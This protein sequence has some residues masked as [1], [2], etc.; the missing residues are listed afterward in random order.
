MIRQ[1]DILEYGPYKNYRWVDIFGNDLDEGFGC[2][3]IIYGRNYAGKTTFSRIIRSLELGKPHKDFNNGKFIITLDDGKQIT[4]LDLDDGPYNIRVYNADFKKDNLSFLYDENGEILPFAILGEEN[5]EIQYKIEQ[6]EK[7]IQEIREK[8]YNP[9]HGVHKKYNDNRKFLD[10]LEKELSKILREKASQIRNN[11]NLFLANQKKQY[12]IRDIEQEIPFANS[13]LEEQ[14]KKELENTIKENIKEIVPQCS[15]LDFDYMDLIDKAI[16]LLSMSLKPSK[17][18]ESLA[19]N[20]DLQEWVREGIG[21]HKGILEECAFCGNKI[22]VSRWEELDRHFTREV[23]EFTENLEKLMDKIK[24]KKEYILNYQLPFDKYSFYSIFE[25]DYHLIERELDLLKEEAVSELDEVYRVLEERRKNLFSTSNM[26]RKD[27]DINLKANKLLSKINT[28]INKNN[29]YTLKYTEKQNEARK[30]L[31]YDEIYRFKKLINYEEKKAAIENQRNLLQE[32][33]NEKEKLEKIEKESLL[34]KAELEASLKDEKNAVKLVNN[35]LK[36]FLGHPELYLDIEEEGASKK[37][38]KFVVKRN[39]QKAKNLSEGEQS[40][41][42]FCYFLATLKDI[43]N[44][45]EYTI[46][47]DDPISSL[48]SNHIFYVFSL[49]DSEI[50]SKNYKQVFISTHNLDLLKYLQK[51]TKP[52]NNK[53]YNNKYYL[54]EK[55]LTANGEATSIITRMP[56]YLQTYSTEFIFLFHQIYRVATEDQS[57]ENYEVF[58]SFPNTARKFIE[59]YMFFKYPDFTMKNDKRIREFFGGKLEFVSFLNRINNEFSHGENQPDRLFKPIDIPE[60]KKNALIILDSIRRNDEEQYYAFLRSINALP[61]DAISKKEDN[62]LV[63]SMGT[64]S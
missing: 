44:I 36:S 34:K 39:N 19:N 30:K 35:Y 14:E 64:V 58:Y 33:N 47:I 56:T 15:K 3:N 40:L 23:E 41:I 31:R 38:S 17:I 20:N 45:E 49:I 25:E 8:L 1:I 26:L 9:D 46:F 63:N 13:L 54:I 60:F 28:L 16:L 51:L 2:R 7:K 50:A 42:A 61:H 48:D 29:E 32:I 4:E 37:I 57:D 6:E 10:K 43:S 53:K 24:E 18:I 11:P 5:I 22:D 21:L 27:G 12:D 52:T 62:I 59:T 55:K